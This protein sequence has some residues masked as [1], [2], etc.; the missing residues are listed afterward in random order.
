MSTKA[1]WMAIAIQRI[2]IKRRALDPKSFRAGADAVVG[3]RVVGDSAIG[4]KRFRV[5]IH[6]HHCSAARF[7]RQDPASSQL[8]G[9]QMLEPA[10]TERTSSAISRAD[11]RLGITTR[12]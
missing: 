4:S 2:A 3:P 7:V 9:Q 1:S 10:S 12:R 5:N 8:Q 11:S 6:N